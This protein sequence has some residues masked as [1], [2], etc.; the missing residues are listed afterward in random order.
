MREMPEGGTGLCP[1]GGQ[2]GCMP[3]MQGKKVQVLPPRSDRPQDDEGDSA[4]DSVGVG[5]AGGGGHQGE[6]T[7]GGVPGPSEREEGE[8]GEEAEG[9]ADEGKG[10]EAEGAAGEG[11]RIETT[12]EGTSSTKDLQ[13]GG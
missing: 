12:S 10:G 13:N 11:K 9:E 2:W 3:G 1:S 7:K 8:G 6:E 4:S 5:G